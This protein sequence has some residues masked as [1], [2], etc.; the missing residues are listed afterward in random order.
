VQRISARQSRTSTIEASDNMISRRSLLALFPAALAWYA[1]AQVTSQSKLFAKKPKPGTT[2][3]QPYVF[4]GTD[5]IKSSGKGIYVSRFDAK[6]GQLS[7]PTLAAATLRPAFMALS[8]MRVA[9]QDRRFLYV[10]NEGDEHTST[11]ST[12]ALD[13][14]GILKQVGQV[15]AGFAGP[16]YVAVEGSGRAAFVASYTGSGVSTFRV[17]PDGTLSQPVDRVDFRNQKVFGHHGPNA[18]RQEAPHPHSAMLSPDNRFLI[19][20]DLGNDTL[21]TFP[22]DAGTAHLDAPHVETRPPGSGPRHLAFHPNG[23]WA[24]SINELSNRIDH[25]LWNTTHATKLVEAEAL[26]TDTGHSVSTLDASFHGVNTAAE[27]AVSPNGFFLY[28]SN[29]GED[30]LVVFAIDQTS[31]ELKLAQRFSCG[32]KGPRHFTFDPTGH[33]L[34]CGN[35]LSDSVTVF[36]RDQAN[37]QLSGPVQ[38]L[39]LQAPMFSL[40]A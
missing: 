4:F 33:W 39:A 26:L 29:R 27:V 10:T 30:S 12:F 11:I 32:G 36:A 9:G 7:Q 13:P 38:T 37:G 40:F 6:T 24:Y 22:L 14:A 8:Q 28:A 25:F 35:Q 15:P 20:N 18:E 19:V 3:V 1:Q 5:T 16:C 31:G 34:V 21:V 23:R 17:Q 2:P